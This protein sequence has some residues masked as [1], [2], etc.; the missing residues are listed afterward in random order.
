MLFNKSFLT[1]IVFLLSMGA[2]CGANEKAPETSVNGAGNKNPLVTMT[3]DNGKKIYIELY[4]DVAPNTVNNYIS[5]IKQGF[6]DG[7]IFHRVIPG[8]MIQGGD[9]LGSGQGGPGYNIFGEFTNNGFENNLKHKRGVLSMARRGDQLNPSSAYN[10]AGSQFFI[11]AADS[12]HLDKDYAAFGA[13]I[14][15]TDVVDQIVGAQRDAYDKPVK[16]QKIKSM[17]VETY[18]VDYPEPEIIPND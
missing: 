14:G 10:T 4:P 9:P 8:F 5:L 18:G 13:V 11:M 1:L 7:V 12:T 3:M 6:Y 17:G 15:G 2:A 16:E